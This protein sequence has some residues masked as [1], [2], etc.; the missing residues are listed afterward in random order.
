[1][2]ILDLIKKYEDEIIS[3][4]RDL[5]RIPELAFDLPQTMDYIAKFL[6]SVGVSYEKY[7]NGSGIVAVINGKTDGKCLA[8]RAD[9]DALP[10]KEETGL[11]FS[12]TNSNMHAC[13]HDAH[14]AIALITCKILNELRNDFSGNVKFIFQPAEEGPGGAEPMINAG[15]LENPKVDRI[16]GLHAGSLFPIENGK[17]GVKSGAIMA[18]VDVFK[19]NIIGRGSHGAEPHKS[20]DPIVTTSEVILALQKIVSRELNPLDNAVVT[21]GV[22]Q[23]GTAQNIIPN[24]VYIEGT[25]RTLDENVRKFVAERIQKIVNGICEAN[26]CRAEIEYNFMYPV[27][28]NDRE[29]T[30][31]VEKSAV[32]ILGE[33]SVEKIENAI[34][35]A[36]D[37]AYYL[38][39]VKG[40]F[41]MLSNPKQ[42]DGEYYPHHNSK[43][44]IDE[45]EFY[46][47]VAV[48]VNT[49]LNYLNS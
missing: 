37:F 11:D 7:L 23:G 18:S 3:I 36:E 15:V 48:F 26:R 6:D 20:I 45:S 46:K 5:H 16:I 28:M 34:M 12:S 21:V 25:V 13:G 35:G 27:V 19:I 22:V 47:G 40:T 9:S 29:F 39:K 41:F 10:I 43:F 44:D 49:A 4:R 31:F 30:E 2:N 8:I 14:T 24:S 17:I 1:M 38:Q 32:E 42:I 33:N